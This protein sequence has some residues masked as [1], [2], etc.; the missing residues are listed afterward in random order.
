MP[1]P[2]LFPSFG[3]NYA[4]S[5]MA[6]G[7]FNLNPQPRQGQGAFGSVPGNI[8][9][10]N[11]SADL[12]KVYPNLTGTNSAVSDQIMSQLRGELSPDTIAAIQNAAAT[13]GVTSGMPGSGLQW[14][15]SLRDL[16][17]ATEDQ[18]S[19]GISNYNATIPTVSGTQ[20]VRPETQV[21]VA[22][23]NAV[24]NSAPDPAA[25][26]SYAQQLFD[27]YLG[28]LSQSFGGGGGGGGGS[29]GGGLPIGYTP[30]M[31]N[32]KSEKLRLGYYGFSQLA[33]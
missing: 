31:Q 10:P 29:G 30:E 25:A 8:G 33:P 6:P 21:D 18:I 27:K 1:A 3:T 26:A 11:P 9:L 4:R 28:S 19:K 13:Y 12:S 2:K 14:N 23:Q 24:W 15:K 20:T 16:G 22:T 7:E 32:Q 5:V 17:I